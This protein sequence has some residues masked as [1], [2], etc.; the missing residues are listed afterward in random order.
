MPY[1][2][3]PSAI[4]GTGIFATAP[5]KRG[6]LLW[7]YSPESIAEYDEESFRRR[8]QP[9]TPAERV[10]LCEHVYCW[11]GNVVEILDDGKYWNH[12]KQKDGQN[13]GN[14]PDEAA[15]DGDGVS[16]YALR[17]IAAGE[18]LTDDYS[19]YAGLPWFEQ[20]C[21]EAG[22]ESCTSVGHRF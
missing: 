18:E 21:S 17:D 9:L 10:E 2:L 16:S 5:I 12:A 11:E 1:E 8:L 4:A 3:K 13:T 22:A 19:T 15:G 6:A 20:I 7:K 14:H